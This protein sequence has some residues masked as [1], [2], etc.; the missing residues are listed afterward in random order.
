M[1]TL[2]LI[3]YE[4]EKDNYIWDT[5][6]S[7][8][9]SGVFDSPLYDGLII[10]DAGSSKSYK[11]KL[12]KWAKMKPKVTVRTTVKRL[13]ARQNNAKVLL[14]AGARGSDWVIC[15]EDDVEVC[16]NFLEVTKQWMDKYARPEVSFYPLAAAYAPELQASN[17]YWEYPLDKFY[18]T[19]AYVVE[20]ETAVKF[21]KLLNDQ[22]WDLVKSR[23]SA[24]QNHDLHIA[25]YVETLDYHAPFLLTPAPYC[26]V[27]HIG[28]S[29]AIHNSDRFHEYRQYRK[30]HSL[31]ETAFPLEYQRDIR[32]K[33]TSEKLADLL[34]DFVTDNKIERVYDFGAGT[35]GYITALHQ[36]SEVEG[37]DATPGISELNPLVKEQDISVPG[38]IG[39][40]EKGLVLSFEVL[41]HLSESHAIQALENMVALTD[42]YLI[43]SWAKKGQG[44]V[45][46]INEQDWDYV[47]PLVKSYG[48]E[49]VRDESLRWRE[50]AGQDLRW[51]KDTIFIF[52]KV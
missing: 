48:F 45:G 18:G 12:K 17:G 13:Y 28:V 8:E 51:F 21:A 38:F 37:F 36:I 32:E 6:E 35:G 2:A 52:K 41:E 19:Q 29:S 39:E 5:L 15:L 43:I 22:E 33:Y 14:E 50:L 31:V 25:K 49:Y 16:D 4:R 10:S 26:F 7:L 23:N 24:K 27:Q 40:R 30:T 47:V 9:E 44:G 11:N 20:P 42:K 34:F 46:H 3:T 1:Y